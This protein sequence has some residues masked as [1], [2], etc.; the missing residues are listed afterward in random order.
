[1]MNLI[2]EYMKRIMN[3][4]ATDVIYEWEKEETIIHV[5]RLRK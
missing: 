5:R 3:D 2:S 1:M 4:A